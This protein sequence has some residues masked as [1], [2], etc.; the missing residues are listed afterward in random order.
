MPETHI[1]GEKRA[2]EADGSGKDNHFWACHAFTCVARHFSAFSPL[3]KRGSEPLVWAPFRYR[4]SYCQHASPAHVPHTRLWFS[5]LS[6][7]AILSRTSCLPYC[8]QFLSPKK[9][10]VEYGLRHQKPMRWASQLKCQHGS[11]LSPDPP[12]RCIRK[13][14]PLLEQMAIRKSRPIWG[15]HKNG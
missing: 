6:L 2:I 10:M 8:I 14:V 7:V 1:I 5:C 4:I 12:S 3:Q 13:V 11:A 15:Y 9:S